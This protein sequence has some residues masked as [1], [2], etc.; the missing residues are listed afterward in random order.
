MCVVVLG[1]RQLRRIGSVRVHHVDVGGPAPPA[2]EGDS[3]AVRGPGG[4]D[5]EEVAF[6]SGRV[7]V[8][9][10][11]PPLASTVGRHHEDR[12]V[13]V[14]TADECDVRRRGVVAPA[15][16][17]KQHADGAENCCRGHSPTHG[18]ASLIISAAT[19][20]GRAQGSC[21]FEIRASESRTC[22]PTQTSARGARRR[23]TGAGGPDRPKG[24]SPSSRR[25]C[26][27]R[28]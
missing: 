19:E 27:R 21:A 25:R 13:A 5:L 17:G 6:S 22:A 10:G 2:R 16:C 3:R 8:G 23:G 18:H 28:S 24:R 4:L 9:L 20:Y 14:T 1:R 12:V 15:A 11:Q 26:G 7:A